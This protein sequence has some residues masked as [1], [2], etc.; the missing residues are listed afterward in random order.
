[1]HLL[2]LVLELVLLVLELVV[3]VLVVDGRVGGFVMLVV[4]LVDLVGV[5]HFV[6]VVVRLLK[7]LV[8]VRLT[9]LF[10]HQDSVPLRGASDVLLRGRRGLL[11]SFHQSWAQ[12]QILAHLFAHASV[13]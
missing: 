6:V 9:H 4:G 3:V 11:V 1:M 12:A 2:L 8:R 5:L 13:V 10:R 7:G